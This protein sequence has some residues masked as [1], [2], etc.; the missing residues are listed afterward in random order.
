[1]PEG[2]H[3]PGAEAGERAEQLLELLC[4]EREQPCFRKLEL[5]SWRLPPQRSPATPRARH[6]R[7]GSLQESDR[8]AG[9]DGCDSPVVDASRV[10]VPTIVMGAAEVKGGDVKCWAA[11]VDYVAE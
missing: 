5:E 9:E 6:A 2:T 7:W 3:L 11:D 10:A 8:A 1:M 4:D